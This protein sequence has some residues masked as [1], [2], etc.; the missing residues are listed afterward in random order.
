MKPSRNKRVRVTVANKSKIKRVA[1]ER[2]M[3]VSAFIR[4]AFFGHGC[5]TTRKTKLRVSP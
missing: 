2:G 5:P 1:A 4:C 3:S